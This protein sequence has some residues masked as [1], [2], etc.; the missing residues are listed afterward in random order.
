MATFIGSG[1][2]EITILSTSY[3]PHDKAKFVNIVTLE[4]EQLSQGDKY[5]I[6]YSKDHKYK[7]KYDVVISP[8]TPLTVSGNENFIYL[9]GYALPIIANLEDNQ[10]TARIKLHTSKNYNVISSINYPKNN[11]NI[12]FH[13]TFSQ[14]QNSW[15]LISKKDLI[16]T[17]SMNI[18][19][20]ASDLLFIGIGDTQQAEIQSYVQKVYSSQQSL[21]NQKRSIPVSLFVSGQTG[22]M[23]FCLNLNTSIVYFMPDDMDTSDVGVL[24]H[25]HMHNYINYS[26][27][28][29]YKS[30]WFS[31]GFTEY[32]ARKNNLKFGII[33]PQEYLDCYN[34]TIAFYAA[35]FLHN[36]SLEKLQ[37]IAFFQDNIHSRGIMLAHELDYHIQAA[38]HGKKSL[39]DV[40][41]KI[42]KNAN[43]NNKL[44]ISKFQRELKFVTGKDFN[45]LFEEILDKGNLSALSI[46]AIPGS[47]L[48]M[49][50]IFV[51][52]MGFDYYNALTNAKIS[53]LDHNSPAFQ[54]GIRNG[55]MIDPYMPSITH[56]APYD[57]KKV[58]VRVPIIKVTGTKEI[59][60]FANTKELEIPQYQLREK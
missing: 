26:L 7:I 32:Y 39:D 17:K 25:E 3:S 6:S 38:T 50:K 60:Y 55:D 16:T 56:F 22:N 28:E 9:P 35:R 29:D 13:G 8:D 59:A 30:S 45:Y 33:S 21:F 41:A 46:N 15:F 24:A 2:D 37:N 52:D 51:P 40:M 12:L 20:R 10:Q 48:V 19:K 1:K 36:I 43:K 42:I 54:V 23:R 34:S 49:T 14:F 58:K 18:G 5:I 27:I 44:T 47:T 11:K 4:G 53:D 57:E 31:E